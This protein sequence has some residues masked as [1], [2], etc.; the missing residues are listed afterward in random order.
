VCFSVRLGS[1]GRF[2]KPLVR[3]ARFFLTI[4]F[5]RQRGGSFIAISK[6][7]NDLIWSAST[8]MESSNADAGCLIQK[9]LLFNNLRIFKHKQC[10]VLCV[11]MLHRSM[12]ICLTRPSLGCI[13]RSNVVHLID[14]K[15]KPKP[16]YKSGG[17]PTLIRMTSSPDLVISTLSLKIS[18]FKKSHIHIILPHNGLRKLCMPLHSLHYNYPSR[19]SCVLPLYRVP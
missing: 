14:Y 16:A 4:P 3:T 8:M 5:A 9:R 2:R 18:S 19:R 7:P 1:R 12:I 11:N 6:C 10:A 15:Y 13:K 17:N